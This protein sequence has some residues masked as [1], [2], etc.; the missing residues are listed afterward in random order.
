MQ[1]QFYSRGVVDLPESSPEREGDGPLVR[2]GR[3]ALDALQGDVPS[4]IPNY[5]GEKRR[6]DWK[7]PTERSGPHVRAPCRCPQ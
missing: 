3:D 2:R 5:N 4:K 7:G 6:T 1:H